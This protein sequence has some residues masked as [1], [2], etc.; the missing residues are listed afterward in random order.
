MCFDR[1]GVPVMQ[2]A[3]FGGLSCVVP[4]KNECSECL[5][6]ASGLQVTFLLLNNLYS[7]GTAEDWEKNVFIRNIKSFNHAM[8]NDY[9]IDLDKGQEYNN[10]LIAKVQAVK[11]KYADSNLIQVKADYLAERSIEDN[12]S[13]EVG[14]NSLVALA[15]YLLMF[16]YVSCALG[17]LPSRVHSKFSLGFA[18]IFVVVSSLSAAFGILFYNGGKLTMI[19]LEVVPFLIL[20]I[21]VDNMFLI[22]RAERVQPEEISDPKYRVALALRE[23]GP[24]IFVASFC[25]ALAFFIGM[26]TDIPALSNF[27]LVAGIAVIAD[28]FF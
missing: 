19:S 3:V 20:A 22:S 24:S 18:G 25:E 9:H 15:S 28:F 14:E 1:I 11:N 16:F 21:G 17:Y 6:K 5:V 4:K 13:E 27:C 12:I 10:D 8:G 26:Q 7:T 23:I 2:D